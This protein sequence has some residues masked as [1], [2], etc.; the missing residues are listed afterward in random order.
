MVASVFKKYMAA[1]IKIMINV[2]TTRGREY[3]RTWFTGCVIVVKSGVLYKYINGIM[4]NRSN[5]AIR[6]GD[7][8]ITHCYTSWAIDTEWYSL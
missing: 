8:E 6:I 2:V 7:S 3:G 5:V 1:V 4:E